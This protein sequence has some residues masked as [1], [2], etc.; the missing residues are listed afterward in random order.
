MLVLILSRGHTITLIQGEN[1]QHGSYVI[2]GQVRSSLYFLHIQY[3]STL[4]YS[5]KFEM[6]GNTP[7]ISEKKFS[8]CLICKESESQFWLSVG[9]LK[10]L[11]N[12]MK[13]SSRTVNSKPVRKK[14]RQKFLDQL[15][16]LSHGKIPRTGNSIIY[17]EL[18]SFI[19]RHGNSIISCL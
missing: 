13:P 4:C 15:P 3:N 5:E 2:V 19:S 16:L 9:K 11:G 12:L 1:Q 7:Q 6:Q 14:Q 10:P 17:K 8:H 18:V